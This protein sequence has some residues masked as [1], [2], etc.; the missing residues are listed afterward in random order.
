MVENLCVGQVSQYTSSGRDGR[1]R[2][3]R[4]IFIVELYLL[5]YY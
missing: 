4:D 5:K 3:E 2:R 1:E